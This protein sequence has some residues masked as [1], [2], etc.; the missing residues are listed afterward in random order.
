MIAYTWRLYCHSST[1]T[2][3]KDFDIGIREIDLR[4]IDT[5]TD[6]MRGSLID[7]LIGCSVGWLVDGLIELIFYCNYLKFNLMHVV[8]LVRSL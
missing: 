1:I 8:I 6:N 7:Y 4:E 2:L 5:K 3:I